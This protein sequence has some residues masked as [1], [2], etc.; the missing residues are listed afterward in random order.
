MRVLVG[1][2]GVGVWGLVEKV[3]VGGACRGY[4]GY[5][6]VAVVVIRRRV[7][8]CWGLCWALRWGFARPKALVFG[9]STCGL[10]SRRGGRPSGRRCCS[11]CTPAVEQ[12]DQRQ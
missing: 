3:G 7:R 10:D 6:A 11:L 9:W 5:V 1:A 8:K 12:Q 2:L 4:Q